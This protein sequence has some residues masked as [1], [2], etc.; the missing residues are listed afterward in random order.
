MAVVTCRP[1]IIAA[2]TIF[3]DT[4]NVDIWVATEI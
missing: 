3:T 2:A 1:D 4:M